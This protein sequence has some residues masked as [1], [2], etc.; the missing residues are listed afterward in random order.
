MN[1]HL[2]AG[3][4]LIATIGL[5]RAYGG[6][7]VN[8]N[9]S[10]WGVSVADNNGSTYGVPA[11][12]GQSTLGD[13]SVMYY[14]L[15]DQSDTAGH[16]GQLGPDY[17]GQ[18]YDAEFMGVI[19]N[20][21]QLSIAIVTGQRPDNGFQFFA[22]GDIR[23]V[24]SAGT[25]AIEVGGG[26]GGG[27]GGAIVEGSLGTTYRLD[28]NGVTQGVLA[29]DGT[30]SGNLS[31]P[32]PQLVAD[33]SQTAGSIWKDP[34]WILD[35]IVPQGAT[36]MQFIGGTRVG[37]SD[38]VYTRDSSTS[39][40]SIIELTLNAAIFGSALIEGVYWRP[41]CGNDELNVTV[42]RQV[43]PEAATLVSWSLLILCGSV[44]V[45][46]RGHRRPRLRDVA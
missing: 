31:G 21:A 34:Q 10:D 8:G 15:E 16:A 45:F 32:N 11:G 36:Q 22:P 27:S 24:T 35:P 42:D 23:I 46:W 7:T 37:D 40:H 4:F 3:L 30:A 18:D 9:L 33:A 38:Y 17:G 2:A 14:H 43:V 25:F 26:I 5:S 28:S 12:S 1:R 6:I 19:L 29:S 13:G 20:G 41:S 44:G 39:Q